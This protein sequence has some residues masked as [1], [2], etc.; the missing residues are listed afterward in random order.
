LRIRRQ[1]AAKK[2]K[3]RWKVAFNIEVKRERDALFP[4]CDHLLRWRD[5]LD[6]YHA[7]AYKGDAI[8][9]VDVEMDLLNKAIESAR[10]II[11]KLRGSR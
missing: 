1:W 6:R 10:P 8:R 11:E 9:L 3:G 5:A 7:T 4:V 2:Q